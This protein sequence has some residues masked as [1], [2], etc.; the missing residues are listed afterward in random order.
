MIIIKEFLAD[1]AGPDAGAEYISLMN[2][3]DAAIPLTGWSLKDKSGKAFSL[4]GYTLPAG[5]ELR[6]FSSVTKLTLNNTGEVVSLFD[7]AGALVDKLA[8]S[9]KAIPGQPF[10]RVVDMSAEVH[11][12]LFDDL[13]GAPLPQVSPVFSNLLIFWFFTSLLLALA[14]MLAMRTIKDGKQDQIPF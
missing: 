5:K 13:A 11:A 2:N 9:G 14:A 10:M 6:F 3:G 1:P 12:K 8:L 4:T 7:G